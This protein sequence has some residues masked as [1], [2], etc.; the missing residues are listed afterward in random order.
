M[1]WGVRWLNT[2]VPCFRGICF[3]FF[4]RLPNPA[5]ASLSAGRQ[6]MANGER[7]GRDF[8]AQ[9]LSSLGSVPLNE[10]SKASLEGPGIFPLEDLLSLR[11]QE[12]GQYI[13]ELN[14]KSEI[15]EKHILT[16]CKNNL[17]F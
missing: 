5:F 4:L 10:P 7:Q 3:I 12:S 17:L 2:T 14:G 1:D 13:K 11:L 9:Y 16:H 15:S 8:F 6:T